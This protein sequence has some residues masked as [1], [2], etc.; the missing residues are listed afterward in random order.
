MSTALLP[1]PV[2]APDTQ[3]FWDRTAAGEFNLKYCPSCSRYHWYPRS[4]CPFCF[5]PNTQWRVASGRGEIYS[6]SIMRRAAVPYAL[7]YVTLDEGPTMM[8][9][10]VDCD[11]DAIRIG[12]KVSLQ[13]RQ[14]E[15]GFAVPVFTPAA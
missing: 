2:P 12:D 11:F 5:D 1:D 8:T 9:N 14:S 15:S 7:A 13:Y 3:Y 6:F 10:I 4:L